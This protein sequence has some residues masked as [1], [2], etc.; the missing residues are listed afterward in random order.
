MVPQY[1][2]GEEHVSTFIPPVPLAPISFAP[3]MSHETHEAQSETQPQA[4]LQAQTE[5]HYHD[6]HIHQPQPKA[7]IPTL[8]DYR[9]PPSPAQAPEASIFEAPR[10]EWDPSR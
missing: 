7:P 1:V 5:I 10:S 4:Q 3:Q 9:S 8:S 6:G 2:R